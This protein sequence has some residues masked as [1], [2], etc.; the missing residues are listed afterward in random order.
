MDFESIVG[1]LVIAVA[2]MVRLF[3]GAARKKQSRS[4]QRPEASQDASQQMRRQSQAETRPMSAD[5]ESSQDP[6]RRAIELLRELGLDLEQEPARPVPPRADSPAPF[7]ASSSRS[8]PPTPAPASAAR[9]SPIPAAAPQ[10]APPPAPMYSA[11]DLSDARRPSASPL[12]P[13]PP[14]P[15]NLRGA[16]G[17]IGLAPRKRRSLRSKE[18]P[19]PVRRPVAPSRLR[20]KVRRDL[21]GGAQS[22]ARAIVLK[23]ILDPPP[24]LRLPGEPPSR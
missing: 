12:P 13:T 23:E 15:Q 7:P 4:S 6:A 2:W 21:K 3:A 22:L 1:L 8:A 9:S 5:E 14:A 19:A 10:P 17:L 18:L 24:G 20:E 11:A 16:P